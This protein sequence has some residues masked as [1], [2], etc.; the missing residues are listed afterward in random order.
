MKQD[1]MEPAG[2]A[3]TAVRLAPS[4]TVGVMNLQL[5]HAAGITEPV[6]LDAA[7]AANIAK[8]LLDAAVLMDAAPESRAARLQVA[9]SRVEVA[10]DPA[11]H[12]AVLSIATGHLE[13]VVSLPLDLLMV[14]LGRLVQLTEPRPPA[15]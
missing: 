11:N 2:P 15:H 13:L 1:Q 3:I 8:R 5:R 10:A 12:A 4:A 6:S 14:E 9:G 7:A